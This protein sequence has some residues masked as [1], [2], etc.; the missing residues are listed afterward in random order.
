[1]TALL[2]APALADGGLRTGNETET[3]S[4]FGAGNIPWNIFVDNLL[5]VIAY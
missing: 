1:M 3:G 2:I 4:R 5:N